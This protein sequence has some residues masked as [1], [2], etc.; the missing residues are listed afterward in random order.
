MGVLCLC[1]GNIMESLN[2]LTIFKLT[3]VKLLRRKEKRLV[4]VCNK[5]QHIQSRGYGFGE[6]TAI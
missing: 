1:I 5:Q 2:T 4:T 3:K 6:I